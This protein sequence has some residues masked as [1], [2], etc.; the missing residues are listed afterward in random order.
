MTLENHDMHGIPP[1]DPTEGQ[2]YVE[3]VRDKVVGGCDNAYNISK[4]YIHPTT[5]GE[6]GWQSSISASSNFDNAL[7]NWK[8]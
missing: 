3:L 5:D 7:E 1:L 6:L 8:N 4:Y 2:I